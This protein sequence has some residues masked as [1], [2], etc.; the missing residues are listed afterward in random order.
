[1]GSRTPVAPTSLRTRYE[2]RD[3][4]R[5]TSINAITLRETFRGLPRALEVVLEEVGPVVGY[6]GSGEIVLTLIRSSAHDLV[7]NAVMDPVSV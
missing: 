1:M 7:Q 5:P 4:S 2:Y 6:Q 3:H